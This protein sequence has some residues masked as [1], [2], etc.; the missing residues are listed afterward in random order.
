MAW[1]ISGSQ[2]PE[3]RLGCDSSGWLWEIVDN[4]NARRVLVE[5]TGTALAISERGGPLPQETREAIRTDGRSEVEK[6]LAE[7]DPPRLI[8][9]GTM[10]C[11]PETPEN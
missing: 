1:T 3:R 11:H 2:G 4:G 6:F 7:D 10:G 9:C 8:V 5:V